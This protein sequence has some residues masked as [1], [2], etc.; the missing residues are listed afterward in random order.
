M[1]RVGLNRRNCAILSLMQAQ[2]RMDTRF[3]G[4]VLWALL[5]GGIAGTLLFCI[6]A[7][8]YKDPGRA[9]RYIYYVAPMMLLTSFFIAARL[10]ESESLFLNTILLDAVVIALAASRLVTVATP[11]SG[12]M[13]LTSYVLLTC[14]SKALLLFAAAILIQTTWL[15]LAYWNGLSNWLVG[16][17]LGCMFAG[18]HL[19]LSK[20]VERRWRLV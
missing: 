6:G 8:I 5:V 16:L 20:T 17:L 7:V 19:F 1:T 9:S 18:V 3:K 14:R 10:R 4:A 2:L 13:V 12:H 15:K 11:F